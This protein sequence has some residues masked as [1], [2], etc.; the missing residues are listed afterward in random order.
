MR[1]SRRTQMERR[2]AKSSWRRG[3][4]SVSLSLNRRARGERRVTIIL[5]ALCVLCGCLSSSCGYALAGRGS[6][7]PDYIHTIGIPTFLN[8]TTVF[9]LETLLTEKVR[10]E[11]IG[12]GKYQTLPESTGVDALL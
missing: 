12:R 4:W 10:A 8:R 5:G 6:F 3:H 1:R 7:L 2:S 11:F 9:N